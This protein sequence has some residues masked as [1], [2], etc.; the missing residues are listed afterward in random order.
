MDINTLA[1][2]SKNLYAGGD[3]SISTS[4][5][6]DY[7]TNIVGIVRS[8]GLQFPLAVGPTSDVHTITV[9]GD[10]HLFV[11]G[12]FQSCN[13]G[14]VLTPYIAIY[15]DN[16]WSAVG[17][18]MDGYVG[19]SVMYDGNVYFAGPFTRYYMKDDRFPYTAHRIA[20]YNLTTGLISAAGAVVASTT[21]ANYAEL[22][23]FNDIMYLLIP[24]SRVSTSMVG[25]IAKLNGDLFESMHGGFDRDRHQSVMGFQPSLAAT[26][27]VNGTLYAG[28]S[29]SMQGERQ[30]ANNVARYDPETGWSVL[31][32]GLFDGTVSTMVDLDGFLL[33][34][35]TFTRSWNRTSGGDVVSLNGLALWNG[36]EWLAPFPTL[37]ASAV[38]TSIVVDW[39]GSRRYVFVGGRFST[40][41]TVACNNV[42]MWDGEKWNAL[43]LGVAYETT[44]PI[45]NDMKLYGGRLYVGGYFNSAGGIVVRNLAV[46]TP[47]TGTWAPIAQFATPTNPITSID[48]AAENDIVVVSGTCVLENFLWVFLARFCDRLGAFYFILAQ[49]CSISCH[50]LPFSQ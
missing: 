19:T 12:G 35:G 43:G 11:G 39:N 49:I 41:G 28:G 40:A 10:E 22:R 21:S 9:I 38:V 32:N 4:G 20:S 3:F 34:G 1:L 23:V 44:T 37:S 33:V 45:I 15:K 46:W 8:S 48:V 36:D 29:F 24:A 14:S 42:C 6:S 26:V 7:A 16:A 17:G 31:G 50:F 25:S 18:G 5:S 27:Y 2:D 30:H 13:E 47:W